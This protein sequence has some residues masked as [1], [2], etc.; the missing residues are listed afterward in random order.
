MPDFRPLV[1]SGRD[2]RSEVQCPTP[3]GATAKGVRLRGREDALRNGPDPG[4]SLP[5]VWGSGPAQGDGGPGSHLIRPGGKGSERAAA[6]VGPA[7]PPPKQMYLEPA[8]APT[9]HQI[10]KGSGP[11]KAVRT[12]R[13]LKR[14]Q[15][16]RSGYAR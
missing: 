15:E 14:F 5:K 10:T 6:T 2:R 8:A 9:R 12:R 11:P 3:K 4:A 7:R 13:T 1:V 16:A